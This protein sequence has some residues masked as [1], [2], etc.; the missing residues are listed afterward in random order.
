MVWMS[1]VSFISSYL[2]SRCQ[3]VTEE[4]GKHLKTMIQMNTIPVIVHQERDEVAIKYFKNTKD[5]NVCHIP[6]AKT[7]T[8]LQGLLGI[9]NASLY[10]HAEAMIKTDLLNLM[11][12]PKKKFHHSFQ[13]LQS[14]FKVWNHLR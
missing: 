14:S 9:N 5:M 6:Y 11:I 13:R 1:N 2:F 8:K 12:G 4:V 7:T 10:N 3:E